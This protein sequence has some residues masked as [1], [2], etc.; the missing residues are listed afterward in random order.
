MSSV[1]QLLRLVLRDL[2]TLLQGWWPLHSS[3]QSNHRQSVPRAKQQ[4]PSWLAASTTP[5]IGPVQSED[6]KQL[7]RELLPVFQKQGQGSSPQSID[8]GRF[9]DAYNT[10]VKISAKQGVE[11]QYTFKHATVLKEYYK[12]ARK[13]D[14][15]GQ[16]PA[17]ALQMQQGEMAEQE[18]E[19]RANGLRHR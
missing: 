6:E 12:T 1:P 9:A 18:D 16:L 17:P 13:H 3:S 8:W 4:P 2:P 19:V 10:S 15:K 11:K 14:W 5:H 7:F